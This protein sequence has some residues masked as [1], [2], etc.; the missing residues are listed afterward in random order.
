MM[1]RL[2]LA[3]AASVLIFALGV[4]TAAGLKVTERKITDKKPLY[5]IDFAYPQTGVPA[6]DG[7]IE[8]WIKEQAK[9]FI[10]YTH[11]GTLMPGQ[12]FE[13]EISYEVQRNDGA[14]FGVLF[15]FYS[16]TGG[17]HPNSNF[18]AFNFVLPDGA[19]VEIGDIFTR[20]GIERIS[21]ISIASLKKDL[22]EGGGDTDW[23]MRGAG[24]I[25]KNFENFILKPNESAIYFD[26]YA[27]AAY[28]VG[29]QEV[30]IPLNQLR[31][32]MRPDPRQPAA[33]FDCARAST[34]I[35]HTICSSRDLAR[36][37]RHVADEYA[38]ALVWAVDNPAREKLKSEQRAWLGERDTHC[39]AA[40]QSMGSCL[41]AAYQARLTA[42][43]RRPE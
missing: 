34:D 19:S 9:T 15:T 22:T 23:I 39:R 38:N 26:A 28:A 24:P 33:S 7:A 20:E 37:D 1:T 18:T 29:P 32:F 4:A 21:K 5:E 42:L 17:A 40:A 35:E 30:H 2:G 27:V 3:V 10:G 8:G 16:F 14:M 43:Q 41:A 36:L 11:D 13:G 6:I 25:G 31:P 12:H